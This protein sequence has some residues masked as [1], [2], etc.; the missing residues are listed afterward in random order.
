MN[1]PVMIIEDGPNTAD[2]FCHCSWP[3]NH[4]NML[5]SLVFPTGFWNNC[6]KHFLCGIC[7]S[8]QGYS[9]FARNMTRG[10]NPVQF[11]SPCSGNWQGEERQSRYGLDRTGCC[12]TSS[13][14]H[15]HTKVLTDEKTHVDLLQ[16]QLT[17][18]I[19]LLACNHLTLKLHSAS[20]FFGHCAFSLATLSPKLW[21]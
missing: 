9:C 1:V 11:S 3:A 20:F 5:F 17:V 14:L 7:L 15:T 16:I 4:K 6:N 10:Q 13:P 2:W 12:D 21:P 8:L 19:Q 18:W